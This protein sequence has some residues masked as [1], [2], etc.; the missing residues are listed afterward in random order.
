[1]AKKKS[2]TVDGDVVVKPKGLFDHIRHLR[3]VQNINYFDTL[4]DADKK[5]WSNYMVCRFLSMQPDILDLVNDIQQYAALPPEQFYKICLL[6]VPEGRSFYPYI[7]GKKDGK[8]KPELV[9]LLRAH[10]QESERNVREY[11][12]LLTSEDLRATVEKYGYSEKDAIK[13]I[14]QSI[15]D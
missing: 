5:S 1:M 3:E 8:W 14:K 6:I 11:L 2:T 7:K 13:L 10:Y 4:S 9:E 15:S 12:E